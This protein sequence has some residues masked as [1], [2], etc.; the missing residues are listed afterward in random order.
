M[1]ILTMDKLAY[2]SPLSDAQFIDFITIMDWN[3]Q[4]EHLLEIASCVIGDDMYPG[5]AILVADKHARTTG[6]GVLVITY[7][8]DD[9]TFGI[10]AIVPDPTGG[11]EYRELWDVIAAEDL[12][13][14]L[15]KD[16]A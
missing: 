2:V 3:H 6:E 13:E 7:D 14:C 9:H 11:T 15:Q 10:D 4:F 1:I 5:A 16:P 8:Y 12:L